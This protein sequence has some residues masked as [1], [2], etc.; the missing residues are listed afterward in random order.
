MME[1]I[2]VAS[3]PEARFFKRIRQNEIKYQS[4]IRNPDGREKERSFRTDR[5]GVTKARQRSSQSPHKLVPHISHVEKDAQQFAQRIAK[6]VQK[7][8]L[9]QKMDR[10]TLMAEPGFGGLI[11]KEIRSNCKGL[12][13]DF[14]SKDIKPPTADNVMDHL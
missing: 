6:Q 7:K 4:I 11:R 3:R 8:W 5:P 13:L 10:L 12:P 14:V 9:D 1:W 2:L